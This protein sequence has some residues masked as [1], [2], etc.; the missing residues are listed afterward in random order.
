MAD[1]YGFTENKERDGVANDD[2]LTELSN[3]ITTLNNKLKDYWKTIYPV[4][5]IYTSVNQTNPGSIF[6]G[7]WQQFA[8]GRTLVGV[9]PTQSD[10]NQVQKTGG[11]KTQDIRIDWRHKHGI[12]I[13]ND[14]PYIYQ[15]YEYNPSSSQKNVVLDFN[16]N[17]DGTPGT[18]QKI[19]VNAVLNPI[20]TD[21]KGGTESPTQTVNKLQ[22][23]ITVY[24]WRRTA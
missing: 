15:N 4:G 18:L 20:E 23:Y 8:A 19:G 1:L 9:D 14:P 21:Y 3:A 7:T 17:G 22:P 24:F 5:A 12:Q 6:G 11:A 16:P 13:R 2:T 10:F